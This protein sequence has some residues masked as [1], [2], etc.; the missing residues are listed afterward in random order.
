[1]PVVL[2]GA[3]VNGKPNYV[4]IAYCGI[5]QHSPPMISLASSKLHYTNAGIK[6]N[7]TFSINIP[8]EQMVEVTDFVGLNSGKDINKSAL[9]DNFYG[10]LKTAPMIK[11]CPLNLECRLVET[12]DLKGAN[13]LFIGEIVGAYAEESY[14]TSGIPDVTKI[15]PRI[16]SMH[17]NNYWRLGQHLGKAWSIGKNFQAPKR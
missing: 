8:S 2:V 10:M 5:A 11:E 6:E 7:K 9:F 1:M 16:F 15:R 3:N 17:D 4:T 12:V 13:E 14:I